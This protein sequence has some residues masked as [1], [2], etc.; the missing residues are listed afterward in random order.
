[1]IGIS[2][3]IRGEDKVVGV[4]GVLIPARLLQARIAAIRPFG[5]G[6][7][8]LYAGDGM[9]I[10]NTDPALMGQ[11]AK[12][13]ELLDRARAAFAA[14]RNHGEVLRDATSREETYHAFAPIPVSEHQQPWMLGINIPLRAILTEARAAMV[15]SIILSAVAVLL[16]GAI[17]Y[18]L[19]ARIARPLRE[20]ARVMHDVAARD[21]TVRA[22]VRGHDEVGRIGEAINA[23]VH[24][25]GG[26]LSAVAAH[27]RSLAGASEQ[28]TQVS[29]Q[30]TADAEATSSQANVV[31][32]AAEQVSKSVAT[33]AAASEEMS[34]SIREIASQAA[35]AARIAAQ[36]VTSAENTNRT[37][38]ELG[39]SS[40]AIGNVIKVITDIAEQTNLLALNATIEPPAPARPAG[41]SPS[42]PTRS[43]NSPNRRLAPPTTFDPA[44]KAS[45]VAPAVPWPRSRR[46]RP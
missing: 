11:A 25:L 10:A 21:L 3:P 43:R 36:A 23:M 33:V 44:S 2:V 34:S 13:P 14:Q 30:V 8:G 16:I 35:E 42:W 26:N 31:S 4:A 18:W 5:T 1:M 27:S 45:R 19:A 24:D 17:V 39:E 28:L 22:D 40:I 20:A 37:I 7:A 46:F 9:C 6:S 32:S 15:H 12:R 41:V 38:V 29:A